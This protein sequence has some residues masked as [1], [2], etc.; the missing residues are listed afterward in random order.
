[1][2]ECKK[3]TLKYEY[4]ELRCKIS[5]K[6]SR[7]LKGQNWGRVAK[8]YNDISMSVAIYNFMVIKGILPH[9]RCG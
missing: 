2:S 7:K 4:E 5:V 6:G 1:M 8:N 9:F 3:M